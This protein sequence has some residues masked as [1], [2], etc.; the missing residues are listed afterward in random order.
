MC[1]LVI[2]HVTAPTFKSVSFAVMLNKTQHCTKLKVPP[3]G[4]S[5]LL[6]VRVKCTLNWFLKNKKALVREPI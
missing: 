1:A 3:N 6:C 4:K 5:Q 2:F